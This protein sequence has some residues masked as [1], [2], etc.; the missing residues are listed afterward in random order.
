M[1]QALG[2][3]PFS[4]M[5][6]AAPPMQTNNLPLDWSA[7][8]QGSP[9]MQSPQFPASSPQLSMMPPP[10]QPMTG[11]APLNLDPLIGCPTALP[12]APPMAPPMP[13]QPVAPLCDNMQLQVPSAQAGQPLFSMLMPAMGPDGNGG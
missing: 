7:Q 10:E 4:Q 8:W 9:T 3:A 11:M 1:L 6:F 2:L 13:V 5:D 12:P